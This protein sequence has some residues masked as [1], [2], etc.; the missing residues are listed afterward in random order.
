MTHSLIRAQ[1]GAWLALAIIVAIASAPAE[2]LPD[3]RPALVGNGSNSLINLIDAQGLVK[4]GQGNAILL[5]CCMVQPDSQTYFRSVY[6]VSAGGEKLRDEVKAKFYAA[7]F[8]PAVYNHHK[9]YASFYGTVVFAV[10]NGKPRLRIFA[11]QEQSE[12]AKESDFIEPQ[13][14]SITNHFYDFPKY[15]SGPWESEDRP[16]VVDLSLSV[17]A[18]GKLTDVHVLK[19]DPPG[20]SFGENAL[21][22]MKVL[23]YLPAFRNGKPVASTTRVGFAFMPAG[24]GWKK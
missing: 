21:K 19:E 10:I 5:I 24:W 23:T 6:R 8:I 1:A 20:K 15:P 13:A 3:M 14:I 16:A 18:A 17:D 9:T 12:L 2:D 7:R 4:R 11:N 22:K